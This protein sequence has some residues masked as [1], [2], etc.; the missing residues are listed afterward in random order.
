MKNFTYVRASSV[1]DAVSRA[2]QDSNVMYI[3]PTKILNKVAHI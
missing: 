1:E 2:S 3:A